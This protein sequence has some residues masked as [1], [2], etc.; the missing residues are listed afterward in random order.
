MSEGVGA[1][2]LRDALVNELRSTGRITSE[3][4]EAAFRTVPRHEFA[5]PGTPLEEVYAVDNPM[6]TKRDAQGVTVSSIS[7]TYIQARMIE[8]AQLRPGATV[9]EIGSGG[10]NAALLAEVVGQDGRVV[11]VDIDTEVV[12][13]ARALLEASGYGGRVTVVQGDAEHGLPETGPFDAIIVTVG[14]WDIPPAWRYQLA[15][16]GRLVVPLRMNGVTRTI[17]FRREGDHLMSTSSEVAGFVPMQGDGEHADEVVRLTD[18]RGQD[19]KLRFDNAVPEDPSRLE[20]VLTTGRVE[21]WSGVTI[22]NGVSFADLHLWFASFLPGFCRLVA[23][24]GTE[25]ARE[26]KRWF[27]FGAVGGD[28]LAYLAVRPALDGAG[29][30][31]G[32]RG[33]GRHAED[34]AAAIVEQVQAWDRQARR[35]PAPTF[36]FWPAGSDL[37]QLPTGAAVLEKAHGV[38]TIV[39]PATG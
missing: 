21:V 11:S 35:G 20:R 23:D 3:A 36:A 5:A 24:E 29:A 17:G 34:A 38:V 2:E 26:R 28:S 31:F 33:H 18:A 12:E 9:L 16:D 4:V 10:F 30:E 37:S 32:A 6:A 27:P 19:V 8:Q 15:A 13:R 14:A 39:W 22:E 7:S 1:V 25:L